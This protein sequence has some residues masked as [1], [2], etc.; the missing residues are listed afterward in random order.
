MVVMR[1]TTREGVRKTRRS[2]PFVMRHVRRAGV[3][4]ARRLLLV[5]WIMLLVAVVVVLLV[6]MLVVLLHELRKRDGDDVVVRAV[7]CNDH[8][9]PVS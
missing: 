6:L 8:E 7:G 2:R 9:R 3:V 5:L 4:V 1:S